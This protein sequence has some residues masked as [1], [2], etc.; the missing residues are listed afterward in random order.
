[1]QL[2]RILKKNL[3]SKKIYLL[4]KIKNKFTRNDNNLLYK[5]SKYYDDFM[6]LHKIITK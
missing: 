4:K 1:M 3:S 2:K 5:N 6:P